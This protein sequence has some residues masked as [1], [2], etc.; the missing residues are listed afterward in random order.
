[1]TPVAGGSCIFAGVVAEDLFI[2]SLFWGTEV[3]LGM[4]GFLSFFERSLAE[5]ERLTVLLDPILPFFPMLEGTD[6]DFFNTLLEGEGAERRADADLCDASRTFLTAIGSFPAVAVCCESRI[7]VAAD[8]LLTVRGLVFVRTGDGD[9]VGQ[10][11]RALA[12]I[13]K[14]SLLQ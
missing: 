6:V 1:M 7:S 12:A 14:R 5:S 8:F 3:V 10:G 13:L 11:G 2:E 9:R 4:L